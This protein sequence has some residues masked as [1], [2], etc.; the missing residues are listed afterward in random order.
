MATK[1]RKTPLDYF[2]PLLEEIA[3]KRVVNIK[4][5]RKDITRG[6]RAHYYYYF[7]LVQGDNIV[8]DITLD[9][10]DILDMPVSKNHEMLVAAKPLPQLWGEFILKTGLIGVTY[11]TTDRAIF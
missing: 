5:S 10:C 9:M 2:T 3:A 8:V 4:C 1:K 7:F 11:I 6:G